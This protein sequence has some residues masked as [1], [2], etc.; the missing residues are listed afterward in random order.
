MTCTVDKVE[1]HAE[2]VLLVR[3]G[4][5]DAFAELV[6][7]FQDYAVGYAYSILGDF[8]SAEDVAQEAFIEAYRNIAQLDDPEAFPG[9]LRR[10]V[11]TQCVRQTRGKKLPTVSLETVRDRPAGELGP[12][13]AAEQGE[14]RQTVM[15]AVKSLPQNERSVV[16]LFYI[17]DHSHREISDFLGLSVSAVKFRLHSA[18]KKLKRRLVTMLKEDLQERRPSRNDEFVERVRKVNKTNELFKA[19][20][21]GDVGTVKELLVEDSSLVHAKESGTPYASPLHMA[22]AHGHKAIVELL[23]DRGADVKWNKGQSPMHLS[24]QET[25]LKV[26]WQ[27]PDN[28]EV[29]RVLVERGGASSEIFEA[30]YLNDLDSIESLLSHD[31][32][33]VDSRDEAHMTPLHRAAENGQ[34]EV[35]ELLLVHGANV[36]ANN[37]DNHTPLRRTYHH[38]EVADVLL[39]HGASIDVI[40]AQCLGR[41]AIDY[42]A[43]REHEAVIDLLREHGDELSELGEL[44]G[45][46]KS[47]VPILQ[48]PDVSAAV[49]YYES[50]LGFKKSWYHSGPAPSAAMTRDGVYL[51][52]FAT[53]ERVT[54]VGGD[55]PIAQVNVSDVEATYRDLKEK[56]ADIVFGPRW[57]PWNKELNVRDLNGYVLRFAG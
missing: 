16:T 30:V 49:E 48:V 46:V 45:R 37:A 29:I 23:I 33:L 4:E 50:M 44:E 31:L 39:R 53:S 25:P 15:K 22:A 8:G 32:A 7:S 27:R 6:K 55:R 54:D 47:I 5:R 57:S 3:E 42:L 28:L 18:R 52:E 14:L 20:E 10:I 21:V 9:W 34:L 17:N 13:E 24:W 1:H 40:D 41:P 43:D 12:V 36:N 19:A 56:G 11:F 35:V 26:A 2:L 51:I 38:K